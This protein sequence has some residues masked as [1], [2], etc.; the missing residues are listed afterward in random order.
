MAALSSKSGI[1]DWKAVRMASG[2]RVARVPMSMG[3]GLRKD[4]QLSREAWMV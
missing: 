4:S 2:L 3:K 1:G